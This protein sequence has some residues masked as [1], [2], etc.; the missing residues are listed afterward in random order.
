M[1]RDLERAGPGAVGQPDKA[2][3]AVG[4]A[5]GLTLDRA[6]GGRSGAAVEHEV[7]VHRALLFQRVECALELG[8]GLGNILAGG[9]VVRVNGL[10]RFEG[11]VKHLE[12]FLRVL[13]AINALGLVDDGL[14]LGLVRAEHQ[15]ADGLRQCVGLR[16]DLRLRRGSVL[17]NALGACELAGQDGPGIGGVL[18]LLIALGLVD[19]GLE[20]GLVHGDLT[21]DG[22]ALDHALPHG[23][24][25]GDAD[26]INAR[27]GGIRQDEGEFEAAVL[28]ACGLI[29]RH[30]DVLFEEAD[31]HAHLHAGKA[32]AIV[33]DLTGDAVFFIDIIIVLVGL[34]GEGILLLY[35]R[36]RRGDRAAAGAAAAGRAGHL[37]GTAR[38]YSAAA[39]DRGLVG[40]DEVHRALARDLC[41]VGVVAD[42][43]D[44]AA[45]ADL[46]G[47]GGVGRDEI[48]LR[49]VL[50]DNL[51][52][53]RV[54]PEQDLA[55]GA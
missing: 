27:L 16:I 39:H 10:C 23:L 41:A 37:A 13:A 52:V 9:V 19:H 11:V 31:H 12:R 6:V 50:D 40:D 53:R 33:G 54:G 7:G 2:V 26:L 35:R 4:E 3:A 22:D 5:A 38:G 45:S 55:D 14:E 44:I 34:G 29:Q 21:D 28:G 48:D 1:D 47:R 30:A 25:G 42:L 8:R 36:L 49:A 24:A 20:L 15:R 17:V 18:I 32:L 46:D 51:C 43:L